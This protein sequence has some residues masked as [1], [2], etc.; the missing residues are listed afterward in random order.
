MF[1]GELGQTGS[2]GPIG[3]PVSH[4]GNRSECLNACVSGIVIKLPPF[5]QAK[6][7]FVMLSFLHRDSDLKISFH[8]ELVLLRK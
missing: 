3:L 1:Q 5:A 2:M 8:N 4:Y 6:L 7:G